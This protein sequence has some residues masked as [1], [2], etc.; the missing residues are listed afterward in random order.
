MTS[1]HLVI[2]LSSDT[3]GMVT[4]HRVD[5]A[6]RVLPRV[7]TAEINYL[8]FYL[9]SIEYHVELYGYLQIKEGYRTLG[10][11]LN[12]KETDDFIKGHSR[13]NASLHAKQYAY[14]NSRGVTT[15]YDTL[16]SYIRNCIDHP[17]PSTHAEPTEGEMQVSIELLRD[18]CR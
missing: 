17:D 9:P 11:A 13:Y 15:T 2:L 18:L 14:T 7:L 1:S 8:A 3:N 6:D 10:R 16:C 4:S 12:V 5:N